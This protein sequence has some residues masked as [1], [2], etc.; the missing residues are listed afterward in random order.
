MNDEPRSPSGSATP[1]KHKRQTPSVGVCIFPFCN[2]RP[3]GSC[4]ITATLI[5]FIPKDIPVSFRSLSVLT[6]PFYRT[7]TR[8]PGIFEKLRSSRVATP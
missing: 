3:I 5:Y 1:P 8:S 2:L 4:D 7:R 6:L